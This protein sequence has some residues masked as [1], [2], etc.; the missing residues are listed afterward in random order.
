MFLVIAAVWAV[1][2]WTAPWLLETIEHSAYPHLLEILLPV[3]V[4]VL[5][6]FLS[7]YVSHQNP[8]PSFVAAL[9]LGQATK[10]RWRVFVVSSRKFSCSHFLASLLRRLG[11]RGR[12]I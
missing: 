12:L 5:I 3:A 8:L 6:S 7:T 1:T 11:W 4:Y 2:N 9:F 10:H